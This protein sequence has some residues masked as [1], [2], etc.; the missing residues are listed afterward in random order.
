MSYEQRLQSN[1]EKAAK[2]VGEYL[3]GTRDGTD[4]VK[5]ASVSI[6]QYQRHKATKGAIDAIKL[7]VGRSIS[8]DVKE[9]KEYIHS[10]MPEYSERKKVKG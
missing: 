5:F 4:K 8:E 6:T 9:L 2:I 1:A 7:A 10:N 3:D